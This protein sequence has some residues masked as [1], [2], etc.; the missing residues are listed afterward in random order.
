MRALRALIDISGP[1]AGRSPCARPGGRAHE[2]QVGYYSAGPTQNLA[3]TFG[4]S[5]RSPVSRLVS[6]GVADAGR[7]AL[8]GNNEQQDIDDGFTVSRSFS[9]CS[10][11]RLRC[12]GNQLRPVDDPAGLDTSKRPNVVGLPRWHL[13][14]SFLLSRGCLNRRNSELFSVQRPRSR[15]P[16]RV[17][18]APSQPGGS[19]RRN[20]VR[21]SR[22]S[23][24]ILVLVDLCRAGHWDLLRVAYF[25]TWSR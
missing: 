15:W 23:S 7:S 5:R 22:V 16:S 10:S 18:H 8:G 17:G 19:A 11:R 20:P 21:S 4:A 1:V 2:L 24:Y 14:E 9:C 3:W 6:P 13:C 12:A 25:H